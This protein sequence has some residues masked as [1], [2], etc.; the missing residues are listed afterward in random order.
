[1][2]NLSAANATNYSLWKATKRLK[3]PQAPIPPIKLNE[4]GWARNEQ[5]KALAFW[6]HLQK[7]FQPFAATC[8]AEKDN[9]VHDF[10][11]ATFQL[12]LPIKK[13]KINEVKMII[14]NNLNPKKAPGMK[15]L[16][17]LFNAFLRTGIFPDQWK[18]AQII[19]IPKSGEKK[20]EGIT[21]YRP[22][23]L[24]PIMSKLFE[25][26]IAPKIKTNTYRTEIDPGPS[27]RLQTGTRHN[28][29]SSQNCK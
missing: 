13:I 12:D 15:M 16:N 3:Q 29:T 11:E 19:L 25:K 22:I 18:V 27:I 6:K 5:E 2:K 17:I 14:K 24:L 10:L 9:A 26:N 4:G 23:S 21:S 7:V 20:T 1:L 28:R 8:T